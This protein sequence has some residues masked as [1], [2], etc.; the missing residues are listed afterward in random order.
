MNIVFAGKNLQESQLA[1]TERLML[2]QAKSGNTPKAVKMSCLA[3]IH[4]H[5]TFSFSRFIIFN[6]IFVFNWF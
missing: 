4:T 2:E 5:D 1:P 3:V 6:F